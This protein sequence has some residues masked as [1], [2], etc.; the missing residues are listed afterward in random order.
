MSA[1]LITA[2]HILDKHKVIN[3]YSVSMRNPNNPT[4][5][6]IGQLPALLTSTLDDLVERSV[7]DGTVCQG[8]TL[9]HFSS[10]NSPPISE[11]FLHSSIYGR[12]PGVQCVIHAQSTLGIVLGLCDSGGSMLLPVHNSAGFVGDYSPIFDPARHYSELPSSYPRD[13][14]NLSSNL[15]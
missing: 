12:Y 7:R 15:G 3:E 1:E 10:Q 13:L 8:T 9:N 5:F 11:P 2:Y 6:I 14:T 4:T